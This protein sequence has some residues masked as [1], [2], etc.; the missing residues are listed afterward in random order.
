MQRLGAGWFGGQV[1]VKKGERCFLRG[2]RCLAGFAVVEDGPAVEEDGEG[3]EG[4]E[5]LDQ[6]GTGAAFEVNQPENRYDVT[7][8]TYVAEDL[9]PL[10]HTGNGG[11]KS[12]HEYECYYK[13]KYHENTLLYCFGIIGDY[14]AKTGHGQYEK[15]REKIDCYKTS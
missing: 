12:A 3:D 6:V 10:G 2:E 5:G 15:C 8:G 9:G 13:E 1:V 7:Q 14:Q 4:E 11:V